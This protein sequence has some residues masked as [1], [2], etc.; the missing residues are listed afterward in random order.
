MADSTTEHSTNDPREVPDTLRTGADVVRFRRFR[1]GDEPQIVDVIR[2]SFDGFYPAEKPVDEVAYIT[3]FAEPHESH[4]GSITVAEVDSRIICVI[5]Q[6]RRA[7]LV[8][9]RALEGIAGGIATATHP[10]F[11]RRGVFRSLNTW[12][13]ATIERPSEATVERSRMAPRASRVIVATGPGMGVYLRVM[14]PWRA[15]TGSYSSR[16]AR[17][18]GFFAIALWG[19]AQAAM[20]HQ[21][22]EFRV[23]TIPTFDERAARLV[24]ETSGSWDLTPARSVEYLN[25]RFCDPRAGLFTVRATERDGALLGYAVSHRI[26]VRGHIVDLLALPDRTDV[27]RALIDDALAQLEAAGAAAIECWMLRRHPYADVLRRAGF[28]R[29]PRASGDVD[30]EIS[31]YGRGMTTAERARLSSPQARIHLVRADFD[32]I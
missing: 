3:W 23:T 1:P 2:A 16:L 10:D 11:E 25:W 29:L 28:V 26:G 31:I 13:A 8:G 21:S 9:G 20:P 32:G 22:G 5:A 19:R 6:I 18:L 30:E 4:S 24:E 7:I 15:A 14:Q 27:V 12:R 17:A